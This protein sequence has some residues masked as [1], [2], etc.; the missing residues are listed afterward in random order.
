MFYYFI[1]NNKRFSQNT[2]NK[3]AYL[4]YM[5]IVSY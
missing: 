3:L 1:K 2:I 5:A 4:I